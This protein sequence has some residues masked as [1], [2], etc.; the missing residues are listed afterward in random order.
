M[1]RFHFVIIMLVLSVG[2][3]AQNN[4]LYE[5]T[6]G[7][8]RPAASPAFRSDA[9]GKTY[10]LL[11]DAVRVVRYD[12]ISAKAKDTLF[13]TGQIK[14]FP[15]KTIEGYDLSPNGKK[16]LVW[17]N[18]QRIYRRSFLADY[19]VINIEKKEFTPLSDMAAG[20]QQCPVFSPDSRYVAFARGGNL[21]IKKLDYNTEIAVTADG[22]AG[23]I[24][25]GIAD[26]VYEEEFERVRY[27]DFSPDSKLLAFVKFDQ[28]AIAD[29]SMS[30]FNTAAPDVQPSLYPE[31]VSFKYPKAG[32]ANS[33]VSVCVYD[34]FY[35]QTKTMQTGEQEE[36]FYIPRIKW[37]SSADVLAVFRLNRN[38][39][40]MDMYLVNPR[41]TV[42][43]MILRQED[44]RWVDY[45][46]ADCTF[47]AP[48]N[49]CFVTLTEKDGY[50]H[51]YRYHISGALDRRLTQGDW[52]ITDVYGYQPERRMLYFQAADR[53][54]LQRDVLAVDFFG[55]MTRLTEGEGTHIAAF[56]ADFS[57]F[58]DNFSSI[59]QPNTLTLRNE[60][61][62]K[63]RTVADNAALEQKVKQFSLPK[64]EFFTF[65]ASDGTTLNG[66]QVKPENFDTNKKYPLLLV[67]YSG[68]DSQEVLDRWSIGWEYYLATDG[69]VVACIDP[70][71]TG[72][73]GADF[74][75]CTYLQLGELE[76]R[77]QIAAAQ[78]FAKQQFIDSDRI[79][80]WGW[81]YGGYIVLAAMTAGGKQQFKAGIAVAPVT[82]WRFYDSAYTERF[83]RTP[84]ENFR[85]YADRSL[86]AKAKNLQGKLLLVHGSADD[87]VHLQNSFDFAAQLV[88][89]GLQFQMQIYPDK[90][91][92]I[93]G[94]QTRRHLYRRMCDFL[95]ENL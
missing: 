74:R 88:D 85:G 16:M 57:L 87:N 43:K 9:D 72:A 58:V 10:T 82:D 62:K 80:I 50:R 94:T 55:K 56:N 70:R 69:Y 2:I 51:A 23:R 64:K 35:K 13:A 32:E 33:R 34:D 3:R 5:I 44:E 7:G 42:S 66:W 79:G 71:G 26:W 49:S 12:Y 11:E 48:D 91:H 86:V 22:A 83:M 37:T 78:Y 93:L 17:G 60:K 77:D 90:N 19:Y 68:P 1:T 27:F 45:Q 73:R 52:D 84:Q 8:F 18:S 4:L 61:G 21:F 24:S 65:T 38:Q 95:K 36:D 28:R 14:D 20:G 54:P 30:I 40:Q 67:Q 76:T 59:T 47:F 46:N 15:L 39:N 31:T 53:S 6:D 63:L 92:S 81:S 41:S 89:A 75:K 29:F 25:N